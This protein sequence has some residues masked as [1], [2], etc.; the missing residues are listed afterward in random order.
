M[1]VGLGGDMEGRDAEGGSGHPDGV[2]VQPHFE[3]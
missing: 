3:V 1:E 2:G